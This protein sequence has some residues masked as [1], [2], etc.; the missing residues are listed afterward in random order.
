MS[1]RFLNAGGLGGLGLNLGF[2][3]FDY[4]SQLKA[5]KDPMAA[6]LGA[7]VNVALAMGFPTMIG[8]MLAMGGFEL[9][10]AVAENLYAYHQKRQIW[11]RNIKRPFSQSF[12][13]S[14][15][16]MAAQQRGMEAI[17]AARGMIGNEAGMFAQKYSRRGE[18]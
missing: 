6:T 1:N 17:G 8:G 5:G 18:L 12:T 10:K 9:T 3:Y 15:A 7:G 16:S 2:A 4:Q 13:H 11:T 14:D